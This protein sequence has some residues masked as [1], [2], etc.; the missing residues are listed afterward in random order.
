MTSR[1]DRPRAPPLRH[2]V[3]AE[4][5]KARRTFAATLALLAPVVG[6]L[7]AWALA[8]GSASWGLAGAARGA[9]FLTAC[10]TAWSAFFVPLLVTLHAPHI[11]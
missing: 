2:L 11:P 3:A 8:E 9:T 4:R 10:A 6:G 5:L 1:V 7:V